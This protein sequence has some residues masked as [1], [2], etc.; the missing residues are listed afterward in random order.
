MNTMKHIIISNL[1]DTERLSQENQ[2]WEINSWEQISLFHYCLSFMFWV[3]TNEVREKLKHQKK[4]LFLILHNCINDYDSVRNKSFSIFQIKR[5][6]S[7]FK[8]NFQG[9]LKRAMAKHHRVI[10]EPAQRK[11][12]INIQP[13]FTIAVEDGWWSGME[14]TTPTWRRH[15]EVILNLL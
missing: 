4:N 2:R 7:N 3:G 11:Q 10:G 9:L 14:F 1:V 12:E 8:N 13:W 6:N 15:F 5:V